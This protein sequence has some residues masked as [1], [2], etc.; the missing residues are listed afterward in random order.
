MLRLFH[1]LIALSLASSSS[2]YIV[3]FL[4]S[5]MVN[6]DQRAFLEL[7]KAS[8]FKQEP[9]IP[10]ETDWNNVL[11]IAKKQALVALAEYS[12]PEPLKCDWKA[13]KF[14]STAHYI[15]VLHEQ[16]DIVQIFQA[17]NIPTVVLKGSSAAMYYP[18][19]SCRTMGDI[20]ILVS[21]GKY[22]IAKKLL[23]ECG[24]QFEKEDYRNSTFFKN[25]INIELHYHFSAKEKDIEQLISEGLHNAVQYTIENYSFPGLPKYTNGFVLLEHVRQHLVRSGL[26][27]RQIIDWMMFV[28]SGL[29]DTI[30]E[31]EFKRL[32]QETGLE[33]LAITM[34]F[35][36]R[37]WLGLPDEITWCNNADEE[38]ADLL[39][40]RL[41]ADGNFGREKP[42]TEDAIRQLKN[43]NAF[44]YL[45][46]AGLT[47]WKAAEKYPVLRP[48]AWL[49]QIGRYI[50]K[51]T[52]AMLH[53]KKLLKGV[54][55]GAEKADILRRL[56]IG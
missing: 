23:G 43:K 46:K 53:G 47:H 9:N 56:E 17:H 8:L 3:L 42:V 48:F 24:Y 50:R 4:K 39:L 1:A 26:G 41:F 20:D 22:E 54:Q 36:C 51:G 16:N 19:P 12:I 38:L 52:G 25:G 6:A 49:Y 32:T 5:Y 7:M 44:G 28:H 55:T 34:T 11:E 18:V 14:Q 35:M 27:L 29:D 30:W 15:R 37:K 21:E 31:T 33:K 40:T 10:P 2:K 45:Q 13:I